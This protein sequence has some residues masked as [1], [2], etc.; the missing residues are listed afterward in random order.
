VA[1]FVLGF[2][3]EIGIPDLFTIDL[4][5]IFIGYNLGFASANGYLLMS[6]LL[7]GQLLGASCIYLLSRGFGNTFSRW[8][9]RKAPG[10]EN[11]LIGL[12]G[13]LDEHA[14]S[15]LLFI[16][17]GP[18]VNTAASVASGLANV[19]YRKFALGVGIS[20]FIANS[21]RFLA[22]Y[23]TYKGIT[24]LGIHP[25]IWQIVAGIVLLLAVFWISAYMIKD[26]TEKK[27]AKP[28]TVIHSA[29]YSNRT[30]PLPPEKLVENLPKSNA[31]DLSLRK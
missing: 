3:N 19:R 22:G 28:H 9:C 21:A 14:T 29:G 11:R 16:R 5:L 30:C 10:L 2:I 12:E 1:L 23:T 17:L 7:V 15:A 8:L 18:G 4:T 25:Q 6:I 31:P 27:T 24:I 26:W 20:A 13:K